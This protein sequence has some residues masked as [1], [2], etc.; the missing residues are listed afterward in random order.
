L[1]KGP[2]HYLAAVAPAPFSGA[3]IRVCPPRCKASPQE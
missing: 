1:I 2:L 3:Y